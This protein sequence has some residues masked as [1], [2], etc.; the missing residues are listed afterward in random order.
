MQV[1]YAEPITSA[2]YV[3]NADHIEYGKDN[4]I[5]IAKG[6]VEI[7]KDNYTLRADKIIYDK[8]KKIASAYNNVLLITPSGEKTY[9]KFMEL[10]H[11]LKEG[12]V[13]NLTAYL[14]DNDILTAKKAEY[15][16]DGIVI[17]DNATYTPCP[18]C[19][20][21]SPQ[22][23]IRA[24]KATYVSK[25]T[26]T[27]RDSFF[28]VYGVPLLYS[29]YFKTFAPNAPPQSGFLLPKKYSYN[30]VYGQ[31]ITVPFYYR[32][33]DNIDFLY[34][35]ML[36]SH[37]GPLHQGRYRHLTET[38]YYELKGNYIKPKHTNQGDTTHRYH[39]KGHGYKALNENFSL[40]GNLD[41]VSDKSYLHNYWDLN[42]NYL[43]S[44]ATVTYHNKRDY[45]TVSSFYF[46]DLRTDPN[47][48]ANPIILPLADFHKEFF[49]HDNKFSVNANAVHLLRKAAQL[50]TKRFS[51]EL[52]W[53]KELNIN[54]NNLSFI[55]RVRASVFNFSNKS[56]LKNSQ[57]SKQKNDI[58]LLTPESEITWNYPLLSLNKT[59]SLYVKPIINVI[60]APNS[61]KNQKILNEDSQI[62]ELS[63]TNLFSNNRYAGYDQIEYGNRANY[64]IDTDLFIGQHSYNFLI[65]QVFRPK[66]SSDYSVNSGLYNKTFS[67]YVG[68]LGVHPISWLS[69]FYRF[70]FDEKNLT[71]RKQ[72]IDSQLS[73][74]F[75]HNVINSL[76]LGNKLSKINYV[77]TANNPLSN[78][79]QVIAF[80]AYVTLFKEWFVEGASAQNFTKNKHFLVQASFA[81]G[82]TGQCSTFK[83]TAIKD[84]TYDN[85]RNIKQ[86]KSF[87]FDWDIQLKNIN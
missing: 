42:E 29:P 19:K 63:D 30:K 17:F 12:L 15:K 86:N 58:T 21:K 68:H 20:G 87:I 33:K 54:N 16:P 80:N 65:G 72:E 46:Q 71:S 37:Q 28:E 25:E 52:A 34:Y 14:K 38:G 18:V 76:R 3:L 53:T 82:Y 74:N 2:S 36:T 43:T 44:D 13:E 32:A 50:N 84:F 31:A 75:D 67:D 61:S 7:F 60:T 10:N 1:A 78:L 39:I 49:Y 35:P 9:A 59:Y 56:T 57:L 79:N 23:Q 5:I 55:Q 73:F 41:K 81:L 6:N 70:R 48:L 40:K 8:N 47:N 26:I 4:N 11:V 85:Q 83:L 64:G 62:L 66:K 51:T 77:Q 69:V 22:W 24:R 27:Y 45:G